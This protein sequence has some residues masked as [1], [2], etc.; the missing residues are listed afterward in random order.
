MVIKK[1]DIYQL[2]C[3]D[4]INHK[5]Y[6]VCEVKDV[7]PE[8]GPVIVPITK[9]GKELLSMQ[10]GSSINTPLLETSFRLIKEIEQ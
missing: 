1:K 9:Q 3:G 10:S 6:G 4:K 2:K 7:I 8:F 5:H